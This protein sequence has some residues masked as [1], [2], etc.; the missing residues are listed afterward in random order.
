MVKP[1]VQQIQTQVSNKEAPSVS[2]C[3]WMYEGRVCRRMPRH[4]INRSALVYR[5]Q[6]LREHLVREATFQMCYMSLQVMQ[7]DLEKLTAVCM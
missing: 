5:F 4:S 7:T 1:N 2:C 3:D 6:G